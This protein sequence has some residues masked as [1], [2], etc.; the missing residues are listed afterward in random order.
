MRNEQFR[1][2]LQR[3]LTSERE[4]VLSAS[5]PLSPSLCLSVSLSPCR[6]FSLSPFL[7]L[8]HQRERTGSEPRHLKLPDP[9]KLR[10]NPRAA[11]SPHPRERTGSQPRHLKLP[12]PSK[13]RVNPR[14]RER[15]FPFSHNAHPSA[16]ERGRERARDGVREDERWRERDGKRE[17]ELQNAHTSEREQVLNPAREREFFIDNLLVRI[18]GI[19]VTIRWTGLAPWEFGFPFPGSLTST[20]LGTPPPKVARPQ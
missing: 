4:Q 20:F 1:R 13:L 5:L 11:E 7:S 19:I 17:R 14:E 2:E 8:P 12:A 18:H 3:A 6:S 9:S 15:F 10:V 16:R